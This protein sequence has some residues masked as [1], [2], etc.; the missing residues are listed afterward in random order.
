MRL[1]IV[2]PHAVES[3]ELVVELEFGEGWREA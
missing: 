1:K 2:G 3:V